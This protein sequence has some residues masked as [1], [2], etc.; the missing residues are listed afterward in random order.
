MNYFLVAIGSAIGGVG[1]YWLTSLLPAAEGRIPLATLF[2][3]I[4]GSAAIGF[5]S[6]FAARGQISPSAQILLMVGV[7][8][9]FTTFSAFSIQ[10]LNLLRAGE[11]LIA[12]SYIIFSVTLCI[13]S[14][15]LG[16]WIVSR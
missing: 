10:T 11:F 7:C 9:G 8:G 4:L 5:L 14:A 16:F 12:A 1:R 13:A 6:G 2:V 15:W 3:N